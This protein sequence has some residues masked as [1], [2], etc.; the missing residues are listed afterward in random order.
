MPS[1]RTRTKPAFWIASIDVAMRAAAA[2]DHRGEQHHAGLGRH[3][4]DGCFD[5]GGRLLR[6]RRVALG[7]GDVAG[8]GEEQ[9]QVVVDFGDRGDGAARVRVALPLVDGDRGLQA[10]DVVDVGPLHLIEEL[11]RVD[12]EALDV[13]PLPFGEQRVEGERAFARAAHAGDHDE[14]VAR[15]V[16]VDVLQIVRAG[17]ADADGGGRRVESRGLRVE[18][19]R[20]ASC[21]R[22][23]ALR[24]T[25]QVN[26]DGGLQS[27]CGDG[28]ARP[29]CGS[30]VE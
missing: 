17:T 15:D 6:D 29:A 2:A 7:A 10:V 11:A 4:A 1:T 24:Q 22:T 13:L 8:A 26:R 21:G 18:S 12:R 20:H 16:D 3:R 9:P 19:R 14:P 23:R 27:S 5:L 28:T 25:C 30:P